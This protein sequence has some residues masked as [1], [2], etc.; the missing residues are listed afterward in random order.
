MERDYVIAY[1]I[2]APARL[3]RMHRTLKKVATPIQYSVFLLRGTEKAFTQAFDMA[4]EIISQKDD[5][6]AYALPSYGKRL[7]MGR[8]ALPDDIF[9]SGMPDEL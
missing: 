1:D 9:W 7:R 8:R 6:R 5:L 2:R 4:R 3:R